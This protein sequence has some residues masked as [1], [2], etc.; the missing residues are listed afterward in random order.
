MVYVLVKMGSDM[1]SVK[2]W[3]T[4][5]YYY[6]FCHGL[7]QKPTYFWYSCFY[8]LRQSQASLGNLGGVVSKLFIG[9][10]W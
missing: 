1:F 4:G 6:Y 9:Y 10:A 2:E 8:Q 5:M 7:V 3:L